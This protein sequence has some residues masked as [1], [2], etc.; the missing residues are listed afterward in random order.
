MF[1]L[2]NSNPRDSRLFHYRFCI[3]RA[4]ALRNL[5]VLF[6]S[7]FGNEVESILNNSQVSACI[8]GHDTFPNYIASIGPAKVYPK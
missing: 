7:Y 2:L 6:S 4:T 1:Y 3:N 8:Y 5:L